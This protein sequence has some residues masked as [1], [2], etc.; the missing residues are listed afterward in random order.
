MKLIVNFVLKYLRFFA[1]LQLLKFRPDIIGVTGSV[2]KTSA[3]LAM[4]AILATKYATK[5]CAGMNSESGIPLNILGL[6]LTNY[7]VWDW[8]RVMFLAPLM[9]AINWRRYEKYVVEMGVDEPTAPKNMEY[10]LTIVKPRVGVFLNV[11]PVHTQQFGTVEAIAAE[12]GKIIQ[13]LPADGIAILNRDD[14]L[15]WQW[16]KKTQA[17]VVPFTDDAAKV[18]GKVF[19]INQKV[20]FKPAPGRMSLI[21]G[22]KNSLIIDS[23]YNASR[24]SMFKAL[25][26]LAGY[27]HR[28]KMAVLGDMRELGDLAAT[29][30]EAVAERA[31][32]VADV[33][34]SVGPL[35]KQYLASKYSFESSR[36]AGKFIKEKLLQQGDVVLVKGSQN[37]IF[38]EIVVEMLMRHP[39]QAD[40][41]LCRRGKY[42]DKIRAVI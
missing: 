25:G 20:S 37:T 14:P 18:V 28:R 4:G 36:E 31:K 22:I 40:E 34:V 8:L 12:K 5:V 16:S 26:V 2:G 6:K 42:W 1:K 9:L 13:Q 41:L 15:V 3:A 33:I 10:L 7:S 30:H 21:S 11:A 27:K 24:A 19:G 35:M 38:L 32:K 23:S 29:E 17:Q 39:E